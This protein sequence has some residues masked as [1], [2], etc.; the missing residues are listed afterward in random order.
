LEPYN[1]YGAALYNTTLAFNKTL[2]TVRLM[3]EGSE[4]SI[5]GFGKGTAL[6]YL[7]ITTTLNAYHLT[8][9]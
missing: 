8:Y 5:A 2:S 9:N 3:K 4:G 7:Y 6:Y 1:V